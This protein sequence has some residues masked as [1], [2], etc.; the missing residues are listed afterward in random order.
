MRMRPSNCWV[1]AI[2]LVDHFLYMINVLVKRAVSTASQYFNIYFEI[3]YG[4]IIKIILNSK[5]I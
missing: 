5:I 3:M 1:C 4:D 2:V